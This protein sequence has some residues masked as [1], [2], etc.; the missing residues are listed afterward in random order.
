MTRQ[1]QP[2]RRL[3]KKHGIWTLRTSKPMT[4]AE[5]ESWRRLF[6]Y[7]GRQNSVQL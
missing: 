7:S 4:G 2:A 1:K 5:T 6:Q 3:Q